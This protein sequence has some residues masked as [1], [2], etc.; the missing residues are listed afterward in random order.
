MDYD[1]DQPELVISTEHVI[2]V[3][4]GAQLIMRNLHSN[5]FEDAHY[6]VLKYEG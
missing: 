4:N 5:K 2:A 1:G 6:Y 3:Q